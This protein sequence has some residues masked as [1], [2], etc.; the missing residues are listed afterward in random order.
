MIYPGD[1]IPVVVNLQAPDG[2]PVQID[3]APIVSL[4][5]VDTGTLV[6]PAAVPMAPS[7]ISPEVFVYRWSTI[8]AAEGWYQAFATY[9]VNGQTYNNRLVGQWKLGDTMIRGPV[10]RESIV[11]KE[12]T[13]AKTV[14]VLTPAQFAEA[15]QFPAGINLTPGGLLSEIYLKT[16]RLPYNPASQES[17]DALLQKAEDLHDHAFGR[18]EM[19]RVTGELR[20]YKPD[21]SQLVARFQ[22]SQSGDLTLKERL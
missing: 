19:N 1:V 17:V 21:G 20:L 16:Q 2:G 9:I 3:L 12:A 10:A 7:A 13:V 15:L 14:D 8:G 18:W 22:L 5:H 6:Q 4:I 11:A